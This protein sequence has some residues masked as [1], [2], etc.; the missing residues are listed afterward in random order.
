[1]S[2]MRVREPLFFLSFYLL[3][4]RGQGPGLGDPSIAFVLVVAKG[5]H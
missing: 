1:M 3:S 5:R 4:R 2:P